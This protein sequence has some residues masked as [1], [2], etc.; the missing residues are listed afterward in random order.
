[1][2]QAPF[3]GIPCLRR[4]EG[5]LPAPVWNLWRRWRGRFG[6]MLEMPLAARPGTIVVLTD[7]FWLFADVTQGGMPLILWL[8]MQAQGRAALHEAVP[9]MVQYYDYPA[10]RFHDTVLRE[11]RQRMEADLAKGA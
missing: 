5:E 9:C 11:A 1:M 4:T 2:S 3:A 10:A 7:D 6:D 8:E